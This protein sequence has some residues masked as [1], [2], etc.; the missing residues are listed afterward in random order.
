MDK[1]PENIGSTNTPLKFIR[2]DDDSLTDSSVSA[3]GGYVHLNND[4]HSAPPP[5]TPP[6]APTISP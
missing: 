1:I 2:T 6:P 3:S 5:E 4:T